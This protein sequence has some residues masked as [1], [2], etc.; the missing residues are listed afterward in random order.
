MYVY[1]LSSIRN[2]RFYVGHTNNLPRRLR[3]HRTGR[4]ASLKGWGPYKLA[5]YEKFATRE[6]ALS[7]ERYFK[8]GAGREK[9][10]GLITGFPQELVHRF[11]VG[12]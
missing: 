9:R 11:N 4:T 12:L 3:E 8:S 5:Y 6:E 10:L 1:I 7:R 2:N